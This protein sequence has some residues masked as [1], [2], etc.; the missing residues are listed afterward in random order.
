MTILRS[1]LRCGETTLVRWI[2]TAMTAVEELSA[3]FESITTFVLGAV[4]SLDA[5]VGSCGKWRVD[6]DGQLHMIN[7]SWRFEGDEGGFGIEP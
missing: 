7:D 1:A 2:V 6:S 3:I 5:L 4:E